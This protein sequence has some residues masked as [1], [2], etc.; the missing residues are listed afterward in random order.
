MNEPTA[1]RPINTISDVFGGKKKKKTCQSTVI[2]FFLKNP[3]CQCGLY[4][5]R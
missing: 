3:G 1:N 5:V 2:N 4:W